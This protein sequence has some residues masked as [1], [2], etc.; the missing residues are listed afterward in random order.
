MRTKE[1]KFQKMKLKIIHFFGNDKRP[2]VDD[3]N[4][5]SLCAS[6]KEFENLIKSMQTLIEKVRRELPRYANGEGIWNDSL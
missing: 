6:P 5:M 1:S 3:Q 4:K 2:S